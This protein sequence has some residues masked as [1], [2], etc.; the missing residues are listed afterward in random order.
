MKSCL[1]EAECDEAADR[2][3]RRNTT[4]TLEPVGAEASAH[5]PAMLPINLR[6]PEVP[7]RLILP[8]H[9]L[10]FLRGLSTDY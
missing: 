8:A 9:Q 10:S 7:C 5:H 1:V 3:F 6:L 4:S 2:H